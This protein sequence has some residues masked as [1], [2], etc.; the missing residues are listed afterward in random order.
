MLSSGIR[1]IAN[2]A[3]AYLNYENQCLDYARRYALC[4]ASLRE[5]D[6]K[7]SKNLPIDQATGAKVVPG[8]QDIRALTSE[9]QRRME[10]AEKEAAE[11]QNPSVANSNRGMGR[12]R[13]VIRPMQE[14]WAKW[15]K[16]GSS[17]ITK[18]AMHSLFKKGLMES[19][20]TR[21]EKAIEDIEKSSE[22]TLR[23][24]T[25]ANWAEGSAYIRNK[26]ATEAE[27]FMST[28][29]QS[30]ESLRQ[31]CIAGPCTGDW[32][33]GLRPPEHLESVA[34]WEFLVD[35][36]L[37][38]RF[39]HET[40]PA[41]DIWELK[42]CYKKDNEETHDFRGKIRPMLPTTNRTNIP[43]HSNLTNTTC[44]RQ[45]T[46][47]GR[48]GSI[49]SL[50]IEQ[51]HYFTTQSWK[52]GVTDHVRG[53]VNW[54]LL[55]WETKW[56]ESLCCF[57]LHMESS[58]KTNHC[59]MLVGEC[60]PGQTH[61]HVAQR[62]QN[63]GI[64]IAQIILARPLR[65]TNHDT[66]TRFEQRDESGTWKEVQPKRLASDILSASKSIVLARAIEFCL[67]DSRFEINGFQK[68]Y[69]M[70]HIKHIYD[71]VM[72]WHEF[73]RQVR[74]EYRGQ[75]GREVVHPPPQFDIDRTETN[76]RRRLTM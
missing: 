21:L 68:A 19:W 26:E 44:T 37:E 70:E 4:Q 15:R 43:G 34:V 55:L 16:G 27:H 39:R 59:M 18:R 30:V 32:V 29:T 45:D 51:P 73:V 14:R 20:L 46:S 38:L 62:L 60:T 63:L 54:A 69:L 50:L 76:T 52:A 13:G 12:L 61:E 40:T 9:I 24:R 22:M 49:G 31:E 25:G 7:W 6:M 53:I 3:D 67:T 47:I 57:G 35:I 23:A 56:F 58:Q 36:N 1:D 71:P 11:G 42:T 75:Q 2:A 17:T 28:L 5:W 66:G 41:R 48:A 65:L 74:E 10:E 33:L 64:T 8:L 72:A